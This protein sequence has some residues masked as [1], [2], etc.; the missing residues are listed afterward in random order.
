MLGIAITKTPVACYQPAN[1]CA[2][3]MSFCTLKRLQFP[4]GAKSGRNNK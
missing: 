2:L 3:K 4:F 1:G